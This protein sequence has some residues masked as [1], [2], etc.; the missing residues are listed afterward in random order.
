MKKQTLTVQEIIRAWKDKNFRDN[1]SD[2]QRA[3]L[4]A[5]P[6]GLVEIGDEQLLQVTGARA[7]GGMVHLD[8]C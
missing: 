5:N 3:Q 4:P 6:A 2:E 7:S 1:L 8:A